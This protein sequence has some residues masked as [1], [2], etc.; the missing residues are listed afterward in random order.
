MLHLNY[1]FPEM[2]GVVQHLITQ[3][4]RGINVVLFLVGVVGIGGRTV[5]GA[6][7][8]V[9]KISVMDVGTGLDVMVEY[10]MVHMMVPFP[11]RWWP[12]FP[13][14]GSANDR[15]QVGVDL[16][17]STDDIFYLFIIDTNYEIYR[18]LYRVID[19]TVMYMFL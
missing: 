11:I 8:G 1:P 13:T 15:R 17:L 6:S 12:R 16:N 2:E 10:M 14:L 5:L 4:A 3:N 9:P 18:Y 19:P 7:R